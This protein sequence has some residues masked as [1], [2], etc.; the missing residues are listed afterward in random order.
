MSDYDE[1]DHPILPKP[2]EYQI[3]DFHFQ[4]P[5]EYY[6]DAHIDI[7][8]RKENDIRTLRFSSPQSIEIEDSFPY[9]ECLR[10][11]DISRRQWDKKSV[12]V[13]DVGHYEALKFYAED[14]VEINGGKA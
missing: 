6:F 14:V 11:I 10:I 5:G 12:W 1:P 7:T 8:F 13:V 9:A 4:Q 3:I 2:W